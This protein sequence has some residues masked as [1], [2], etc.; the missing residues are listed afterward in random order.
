MKDDDVARL[1]KVMVV[2]ITGIA[3]YF[4]IYSSTTLV[5]LLLLAYAGIA[6]FFPGVVCRSL[7]E[8]RDHGGRV[9][10]YRGGSGHGD[11]PCIQQTRSIYRLECRFCRAVRERGCYRGGKRSY[12]RTTRWIQT[13]GQPGCGQR[14]GNCKLAEGRFRQRLLLCDFPPRS[15]LI[16]SRKV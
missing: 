9:R 2:V 7:L 12:S 3:L 8:T 14:G 13:T 1:A 5:G 6:Q 15:T 16:F 10:R 11:D 4:A